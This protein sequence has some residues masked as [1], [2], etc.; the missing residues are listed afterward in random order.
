MF[1]ISSKYL[2]LKTI[3]HIFSNNNFDNIG[4]FIAN[5]K[6]KN[7]LLKFDGELYYVRGRD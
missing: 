5:H 7:L 1:D 6:T 3:V 4:S 2:Y